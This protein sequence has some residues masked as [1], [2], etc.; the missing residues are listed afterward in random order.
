MRLL[1]PAARR[2]HALDLRF[3]VAVGIGLL[4]LDLLV[5]SSIG[6]AVEARRLERDRA[7]AIAQTEVLAAVVAPSLRFQRAAALG[8]AMAP[9]IRRNPEL[10][11]ARFETEDGDVLLSWHRGDAPPA[12]ADGLFEVAV[13]ARGADGA[14]VGQVALVWDHRPALAAGT[15]NRVIVSAV[16]T[17]TAA[18]LCSVVFLL[19]RARLRRSR[20]MEEASLA[21]ARRDPLTG[22]LNRRGLADALDDGAAGPGD[23]ARQPILL[24]IGD[25]DGFKPVNDTHGHAAGDQL[26]RDMAWRL[27]QT[28][29]DRG[30]AARLGGDEF[31]IVMPLEPEDA[32]AQVEEIAQKLLS[33]ADAPFVLQPGGPEDEGLGVQVRV[34]ISFG[35]AVAP[36]DAQDASELMRRA[37]AALYRAKAQGRGR[38]RRFAPEMDPRFGTRRGAARLEAEL[39]EAM[40]TDVLLCHYQPIHSL[41]S[42]A[43]VGFEALAR[44]PHERRGLVPPSE[45]IP[46]AEQAG[47]IAPL[48]D[49]LLRAACRD[50]MAWPAPVM[51]SF[52]ISPLQLRDRGLLRHVAAALAATGLPPQR[53]QLELTEGALVGDMRL[54][55]E[56]LSELRALGVRLALDDFGTGYSGLKE[57]QALPFDTIKVDAGFVRAMSADRGARKIVAAVVGLGESLGLRV[58]AE[59]VEEAAE[60]DYLRSLGCDC[61]QGWLYGRPM[62]PHMARAWAEKG[63]DSVPALG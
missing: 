29:G 18:T 45:F 24:A 63:M 26:L 8:P 5:T 31:A 33:V 42:G 49:A 13:L 34:G 39:R 47:L 52:N 15:W 62:P 4:L 9:L 32:D 22:L 61:G 55:R 25:L 57:L 48:T 3:V 2:P 50:A 12:R 43:L 14:L 7:A 11:A 17:L 27:A 60:A 30:I 40:A 38:W 53:L 56:L 37:D 10:V 1:S 16:S 41:R 35:L 36:E 21:L 59:G 51:L 28:V 54:G 46:I 58:V 6:K 19:L 20:A 44:W 23:P